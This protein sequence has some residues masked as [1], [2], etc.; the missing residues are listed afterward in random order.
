MQFKIQQVFMRLYL[1]SLLFFCSQICFAQEPTKYQLAP[2]GTLPAIAPMLENYRSHPES[3]AGERSSDTLYV[4]LQLHLLAKDN[5]VGRISTERLLDAFCRLNADYAASNIRFYS[6]YDW[7]L[8]DSTAWYMHDSITEGIDMMLANNIPDALNIYFASNVAGNC[9]YNLPYG[10]VAIAHGCAGA[11]DHTWAHEIGHALSLP[12]PFLGWEGKTYSPA[13]PTPDTLTYDY[14]HFHDTLDLTPAP[15]DTTVSER[16]DGS[17]CAVAAD[18]I[19]DTQADYLSYRW[20]CNDQNQSIAVQTDINGASFRSDGT[21]YMSYALDGC[22]SRFS[23]EQIA[24]MRATLETEKQIWLTENPPVAEIS[25]PVTLQFP[26]NEQ[27]APPIGALAQWSSVPGATHYLIQVSLL[28]SFIAK[29][30]DMVVTDTNVVLPNLL[31]NKKYYW[32]VRPFN[33]WSTCVP[34]TATGVFNTTAIVS[35]TEPEND[36]WRCYPTLLSPGQ[37]MYLEFPATWVN[38]PVKYA[39]YDAAGRAVWQNSTLPAY[40]QTVLHLPMENWPAGVYRLR[41]T[42][43]T[44]LK[45]QTVV[46][47]R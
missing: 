41:A 33:N 14:T 11:G 8:I 37:F 12:H 17:N 13:N 7:H 34:F 9:G 38:H 40:N 22:Q 10:G 5:G 32:R 45:W 43:E 3:F 42:G 21:L 25:G 47:G 1:L 26:I 31:P 23:N 29:A 46:V 24:I 19:C 30:V 18:R 39:V 2:C 28:Q 44:G 15:L 6:K 16:L 35:A 36:G 27:Q 20:E 4:A